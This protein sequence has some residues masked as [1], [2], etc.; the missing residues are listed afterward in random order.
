MRQFVSASG[1]T[2]GLVHEHQS[3][4]CSG[5]IMLIHIHVRSCITSYTSLA[6]IKFYTRT[7]DWT[8]QQV[9]KQIYNGFDVYNDT[10]AMHILS[11]ARCLSDINKVFMPIPIL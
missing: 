8:D 9:C 6:V 7:Q 3:L 4:V 2:L 1:H 10:L 5:T 11:P